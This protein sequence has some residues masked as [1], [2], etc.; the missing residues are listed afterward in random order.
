MDNDIIGTITD[1][2]KSKLRGFDEEQAYMRLLQ[3]FSYAQATKD[4]AFFQT[5][6]EKWKK[7]FPIY[8]F[9]D[10]YKRK[11]KYMLSNEFLDTVLKGF[12]AFDELSKKDPQKGLEKLRK[13]FA[14]AE[15]HK[16]SKTLDK[17]LDDL[18][19]EYPLKFLK[20]K[21]PHIVGLI[22]SKANRERVLQKFDSSDAFMELDNIVSHP[23]KFQNAQEFIDTLQEYQRLF[24]VAD[25]KPDY[26]DRVQK[27]LDEFLDSKKLEELFPFVDDL[28]LNNGTVIPLELQS[29]VKNI[30]VVCKDALHDFFKIVDKNKGDINNL[31]NWLYKYSPYIND[32][33]STTKTAIVDNLMSK[34]AYEIPPVGT[35]YK[36]PQMKTGANELLSLTEFHSIDDTKKEAIIQT[37]GLLSTGQSL[38]T[39]DIY[40]LGIINLNV[41][42]VKM[43]EKSKI[44]AKLEIFMDKFPEDKL[45]PNDDIYLKPNSNTRVAISIDNDVDLTLHDD[46]K[47]NIVVEEEQ[48]HSVEPDSFRKSLEVKETLEKVNNNSDTSG[49]SDSSSSSG[50]SSLSGSIQEIK[51]KNSTHDNSDCKDTEEKEEA[52][53]PITFDMAN[54]SS[55]NS[56]DNSVKT[57]IIETETKNTP[58]FLERLANIIRHKTS[59]GDD[60]DDR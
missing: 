13:I 49:S 1:E 37:L 2:T 11:I 21:Y 50:G 28:D 7:E 56:E 26:Q 33:D 23:D 12:I 51:V 54:I 42:K 19:K 15:K 20:E 18:Y 53:T 35:Q 9:S 34:Y 39:D 58:T 60:R 46:D 45:T 24:P 47:D 44:E 55:T 59:E 5:E 14:N 17:E 38:S 57:V 6:L 40:R 16:N 25:F 29:S 3:I 41:Q 31:F 36:I 22:L 30:S 27:T 43:I 32:F 10:D 8:L 52:N 4:Y 48:I